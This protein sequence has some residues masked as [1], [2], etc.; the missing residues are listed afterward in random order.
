MLNGN[1]D[2]DR[3]AASNRT[4]IMRNFIRA[5]AVLAIIWSAVAFPL[6]AAESE[7]PGFVRVPVQ[8]IAALGDP[9]A[10][11][12]TGA[13]QWGIWPIDPA[14]TG[15]WLSQYG[16]LEAT[17]G[18]GPGG[19]R[20]DDQDWWL[21]EHGLIMK[22]PDVPLRPGKYIVTGN[23]EKWSTLTIHEP[24]A[25]GTARW[26]LGEGATLYD[27]THLRCR[28]ARYRPA[29]AGKVCSPQNAPLSAFKVPPGAAMPDVPGCLRQD[30]HVLFVIALSKELAAA[31][32]P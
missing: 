24:G 5:V 29:S 27:V 19:W 26:E 10:R 17:G 20:F 22:K 31:M 13:E 14:P 4:L 8:F 16:R 9:T 1:P 25:D 3:I 6:Q 23:R 32:K 12:G 28:S 15:V 21:E 2:G 11:S 7:E 30:Y 18:I